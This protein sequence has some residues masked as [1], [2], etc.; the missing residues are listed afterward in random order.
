[1]T[2]QTARLL[3]CRA[4]AVSVQHENRANQKNRNPD[5]PDDDVMRL[6]TEICARWLGEGEA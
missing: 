3:P 4:G 5:F 1:M 2:P 6:L